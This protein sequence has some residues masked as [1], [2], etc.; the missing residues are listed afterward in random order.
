MVDVSRVLE[1]LWLE[2]VAGSG[3][4]G[5]S[6]QGSRLRELYGVS[7]VGIA[8]GA[9]FIPTPAADYVINEGDMLAILGTR[10][11]FEMLTVSV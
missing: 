9:E 2:V 6:L 11:Q 10:T 1:L 5:A 8:R 7:V 3:L 4:A